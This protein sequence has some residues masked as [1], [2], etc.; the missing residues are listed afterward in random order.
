MASTSNQAREFKKQAH[1]A[2]PKLV[3]LQ[4]LQDVQDM[5][6]RL[7]F[8]LI[9][10]FMTKATQAETTS[11]EYYALYELFRNYMTIG[12]AIDEDERT[13]RK[14]C[15]SALDKATNNKIKSMLLLIGAY[16]RYEWNWDTFTEKKKKALINRLEVARKETVDQSARD[17]LVLGMV[18]FRYTWIKED[19][20]NQA[21]CAKLIKILDKQTTPDSNPLI[22]HL[23]LVAQLY[24][25]WDNEKYDMDVYDF[26]ELELRICDM[27]TEASGTAKASLL[28]LFLL[29]VEW[30]PY[31]LDW[32]EEQT[33]EFWE[34]VQRLIK[35]PYS[36]EACAAAIARYV[37]EDEDEEESDDDSSSV[38]SQASVSSDSSIPSSPT[39][40]PTASSL[41]PQ[42][43]KPATK[44]T[45]ETSTY[46][47]AGLSDAPQTSGIRKRTRV[48]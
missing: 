17:L 2:I 20:D 15:N 7:T 22:A 6:A 32:D 29:Y 30:E 3:E 12:D 26:D 45:R 23:F 21:A 9:L 24:I 31:H 1:L 44:R 16:A 47:V 11:D 41:S 43:P 46:N 13:V 8:V 39:E 19:E 14:L 25:K 28:M 33:E 27:A 35:D 48:G 37:V 36:E 10:L 38:F 5:P 34:V 4:R 40:E 18:L 42:T